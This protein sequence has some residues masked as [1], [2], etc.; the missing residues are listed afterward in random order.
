LE[1][2][3]QS[4][5]LGVWGLTDTGRMRTGNQD[6]FLALELAPS[7]SGDGT[8]FGPDSVDSEPNG[9][10]RLALGPRGALLLV[11]DGMGGAAGGEVASQLAV[12]SVAEALEH[13]WAGSS[14]EDLDGFATGLRDAIVEAHARVQAYS[15]DRPWLQGMG[16]TVTAVGVLDSSIAIAQVGD[17]RAYLLRGERLVQ[18]TRDQTWVQDMVDSGTMTPEEARTSPRRSV[19][20]Q[21]LGATSNLKVPVSRQALRPGDVLVLCSDGLAGVLSDDAITETVL[22]ASTLSEACESL[23]Q[24]AN[25]AGGP[26]NITVLLAEPRAR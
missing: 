25:E 20:I 13:T 15:A 8:R 3:S 23:V 4:F 19:L 10:R 2:A 21:A 12:D 24:R 11:A 18:L 16:T 26:D 14:S 9:A 5:D 7:P 6:T 22:G 17:S 1:P